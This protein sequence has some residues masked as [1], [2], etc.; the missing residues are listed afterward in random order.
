M[1]HEIGEIKKV[2]RVGQINNDF[3]ANVL[4]MA[5]GKEFYRTIPHQSWPIHHLQKIIGMKI[6]F[7]QISKDKYDVIPLN[8]QPLFVTFEFMQILI[9]S[10][11]EDF[12]EILRKADDSEEKYQELDIEQ[13]LRISMKEME[14]FQKYINKKKKEIDDEMEDIEDGNDFDDDDGI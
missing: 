4:C 11:A 1:K 10:G 13:R 5:N 6:M 12:L 9:N 3:F 14:L 7:V 2:I 8:F